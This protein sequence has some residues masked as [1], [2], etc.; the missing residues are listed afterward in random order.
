MLKH[1]K[2]TFPP[3]KKKPRTPPNR[4]EDVPYSQLPLSK[5]VW[6]RIYVKCPKCRAWLQ[7]AVPVDAQ[8]PTAFA[9]FVCKSYHRKVI[10]PPFEKK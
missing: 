9:C 10:Y 1:K 8:L 6:S 7:Q 3:W 5:V 4:L 2:I